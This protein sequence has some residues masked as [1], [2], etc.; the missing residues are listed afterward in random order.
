[1]KKIGI[2][3]SEGGMS[4]AYS[5]G[6]ILALVE[7]YNLT[8]PYLVIGSSGSSG[9]LAY[10]VAKQYRSIRNIWENLLPTR[11]FISYVRF[12]R[13]MD[14]DYLIDTVFKKQDVLDVSEI[15]RSKIKFFITT[16]NA[17]T[18]ETVYFSNH[19]NVDIFEVLRASCAAP[20]VF[21]K[22]V[23]ID[24]G[25]YLDGAIGSPLDKNI[26]KAKNEGA[27]II[28]AIDNADRST[29]SN[30]PL[31]TYAFFKNKGLSRK[32]KE[33]CAYSPGMHDASVIIIS[34]SQKLPIHTLD[35]NR[36]D[37]L[38]AISIGYKDAANIKKLLKDI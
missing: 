36:E 4:C 16:T 38:K 26:Q 17:A 5:V 15:R 10:Y 31:K 28:I 25:R 19:D 7:K 6:V 27:E 32:I 20:L 30:L 21:N 37:I 33:Y 9:T 8:E 24:G 1:M 3:A 12:W 13:I 29:L 2:V 18:G 11:S 34:P 22:L 14:I 23:K 35:N